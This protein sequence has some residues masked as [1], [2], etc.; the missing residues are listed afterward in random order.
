MCSRYNSHVPIMRAPVPAGIASAILLYFVHKCQQQWFCVLHIYVLCGVTSCIY[1]V[2][3]MLLLCNQ[4][5]LW[6]I[7]LRTYY[8]HIIYTKSRHII[9]MGFVYFTPLL[10]FKRCIICTL[11]DIKLQI[12]N[13]IITGSTKVHMILVKQFSSSTANVSLFSQENHQKKI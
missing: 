4:A 9:C 7:P 12:S 10:K 5:C 1:F 13:S 2:Y 3:M 11:Y 6:Y 8:L